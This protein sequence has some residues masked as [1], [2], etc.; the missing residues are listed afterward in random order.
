M[1]QTGSRGQKSSIKVHREYFLPIAVG[2]LVNSADD[3]DSRIAAENIDAAKLLNG[4]CHCG[5]DSIFI[6]HVHGNSTYLTACC[7]CDFSRGRL[8]PRP[9]QIS[10]HHACALCSKALRN[11]EADAGSR[12]GDDCCFSL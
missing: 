8:R 7:S 12:A 6:G 2:Q 5:V 3:L 9:V 4:F 1:P 10:D 11:A